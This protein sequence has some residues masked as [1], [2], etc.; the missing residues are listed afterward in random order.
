MNCCFCRKEVERGD[1]V[2]LIVIDS[3][4]FKDCCDGAFDGDDLREFG[5]DHHFDRVLCDS[6]AHLPEAVTF[7]ANQY[8]LSEKKQKRA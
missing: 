3:I 4:Q 7:A 6:C 2:T 1:L 5:V 8:F